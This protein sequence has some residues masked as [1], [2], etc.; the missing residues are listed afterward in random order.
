MVDQGRSS[1]IFIYFRLIKS[2]ID[3]GTSV[4][5]IGLIYPTRYDIPFQ[6]RTL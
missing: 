1:S 6:F 4:Q 3:L 5:H 2:N